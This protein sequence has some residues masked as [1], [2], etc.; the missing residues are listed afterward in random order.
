V[1]V[2]SSKFTNWPKERSN[3]NYSKYNGLVVALFWHLNITEK[4]SSN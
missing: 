3:S 1:R 2:V 4:N